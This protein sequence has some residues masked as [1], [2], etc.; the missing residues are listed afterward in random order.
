MEMSSRLAQPGRLLRLAAWGL[1]LI[2]LALAGE[3][4]HDV[5]GAAKAIPEA[6]FDRAPNRADSKST[7]SR[8][9]E[10]ELAK[11]WSQA[12]VF[13]SEHAPRR[14]K[15]IESI[16]GAPREVLKRS[17]VRG[18]RRV[19]E[20]QSQSPEL[21][22]TRVKEIELEDQVYGI[23]FSLKHGRGDKAQLQSELKNSVRN[24]FDAGLTERQQRIA[25]LDKAIKAQRES[26]DSDTKRKDQ[27]IE[28]RYHIVSTEGVEGAY[29]GSKHSR[30]GASPGTSKDP[31][32]EPDSESPLH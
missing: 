5:T 17:L 23:C 7:R 21:Y 24:L 3:R 26:L 22:A 31:E 29:F 20:L 12:R 9:S 25:I 32:T 4:A 1:C 15:Q 28:E 30:A 14:L 2:P 16:P 19:A 11:E 10:E 8:M 13:L 27:L 6:T 18:W